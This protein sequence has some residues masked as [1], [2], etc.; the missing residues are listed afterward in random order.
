MFLGRGRL[1][2]IKGCALREIAI[3]KLK[4]AKGQTL[5]QDASARQKETHTQNKKKHISYRTAES[6]LSAG[7]EKSLFLRA[8][9][10]SFFFYVCFH[11]VP[12]FHRSLAECPQNKWGGTLFFLRKLSFLRLWRRS[13]SLFGCRRSAK[14]IASIRSSLRSRLQR[15]GLGSTRPRPG[16]GGG[17]GPEDAGWSAGK[18]TAEI[19]ENNCLLAGTI[20]LP[21]ARVFEHRASRGPAGHSV[22]VYPHLSVGR[23]RSG[24]CRRR[25]QH[26]CEISATLRK[27][28]EK[29]KRKKKKERKR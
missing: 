27:K 5:L 17:R 2:R 3:S 23:R 18:L 10:L 19:N 13:L 4:A 9:L 28:W 15:E 20:N 21:I 11:A 14:H 1:E 8:V 12:T 16:R 7:L 22:L 24:S 26:L 29:K 6:F 25:R